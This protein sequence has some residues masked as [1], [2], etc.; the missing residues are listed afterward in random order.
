[1]ANNRQRLVRKLKHKQFLSEHPYDINSLYPYLFIPETTIIPETPI[2]PEV[3]SISTEIVLLKRY[4]LIAERKR[5]LKEQL[6]SVY[7]KKNPN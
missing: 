2:T 7:N 1:M 3:E 6:N 5:I 4:E